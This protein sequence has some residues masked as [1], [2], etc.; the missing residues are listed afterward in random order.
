[1][2]GG[3]DSAELTRL[4]FEATRP[5][6]LP[7]AAA[8]VAIATAMAA[9]DGA[10]HVGAALAA[11]AGA[12]AIQ[13]GANFAN[14]YFDFRKGTDDRPTLGRRRLLPS[15]LIAPG[16]MARAAGLAFG[17]AILVGLFLVWRG[18]W[19]VVGVGVAS[20]LAGLLYTGGPA[21]YGYRGLGDVFVLVFFG[22]VAVAGAYYVQA[23]TLD[24][25]PVA[26]GLGPGLIAC[27]ILAVNNLRDADSDADS[28]KRTLAVIFGKNFARAEHAVCIVAGAVLTPLALVLGG[29]AGPWALA[30]ALTLAPALPVMRAVARATEPA[31]L[32][33]A[34]GATG[35]LLALYAV[36]FCIGWSI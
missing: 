36:L 4:W 26:A 28:G 8:P 27:A 17:V 33:A 18:G 13:I 34:L 23:L 21:P 29:A 9:A 32:N 2:S 35:R 22:P 3:A 12:L 15:G 20:I 25:R 24:W 11:L 30:P 10:A 14:D 5:R 16:A 1:M 7:A 19:P 31:R 6:T